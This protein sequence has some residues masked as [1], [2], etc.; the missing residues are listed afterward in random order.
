MGLGLTQ[1]LY[2]EERERE[3]E[4][5]IARAEREKERVVCQTDRQRGTDRQTDRERVRKRQTDRQRERERAELFAEAA[6]RKHTLE[7]LHEPQVTSIPT[8]PD[9]GYT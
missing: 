1:A 4:R 7:G 6:E 5:E 9:S 2:E 8:S 3:R